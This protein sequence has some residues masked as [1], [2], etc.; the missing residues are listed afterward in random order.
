MSR[1]APD[2]RSPSGLR[3]VW[4][5]ET[6]R[7]YAPALAREAAR[8]LNY[9]LL[10]R[11]DATGEHDRLLDAAIRGPPAPDQ[12]LELNVNALDTA[13]Q[14]IEVNR[15]SANQAG[16]LP[17]VSGGGCRSHPAVTKSVAT[18]Q[19]PLRTLSGALY[20]QTQPPGHPHPPASGTSPASIG[21]KMPS[22]ARNP[23]VCHSLRIVA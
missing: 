2:H 9:L 12:G 15:L 19:A 21:P 4:W 11:S 6:G 7:A 3:T 17:P 8:G 23:R 18:G 20:M 5:Q 1:P 22:S 10:V 13:T 14:D 16:Y